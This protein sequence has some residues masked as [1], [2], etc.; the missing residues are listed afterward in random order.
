MRPYEA[1]DSSL[2]VLELPEWARAL[3]LRTG[4]LSDLPGPIAQALV[5]QF[6]ID[7]DRTV[8]AAAGVAMAPKPEGLLAIANRLGT[9]PSELVVVGCTSSHF[10]AA[11]HAGAVSIGAGWVVDMDETWRDCRPDVAARTPEDVAEAMDDAAAMRL[12]AE[13]LVGG[14]EPKLHSGSFIQ[15]G[16]KDL[17][18]GRHFSATDRRLANHPV[19][20][21]ILDAK[22]GV[23]SAQRLGEVIA[24]GADAA[25]LPP[26][27]L[28]ASVPGSGDFDRFAAARQITAARLGASAEDLVT[29]TEACENYI[30][31]QRNEPPP[32]GPDR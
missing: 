17:A 13:V 16:P 2:S 3:G 6:E 14:G 29:M 15:I 5:Q 20:Q 32:H 26:I 27:D 21:L 8:D 1:A 10:A 30:M 18:C 7:V 23:T 19:T 24:A 25:P 28:V 9:A 4:V 11:A 12:L 31:P 22:G